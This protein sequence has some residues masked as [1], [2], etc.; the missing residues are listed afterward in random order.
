MRSQVDIVLSSFFLINVAA[1]LLTA[2]VDSDGILVTDLKVIREQYL[3][4]GGLSELLAAPPLGLIYYTL[5]GDHAD[6]DVINTLALHRLLMVF[7]QVRSV[8]T[9]SQRT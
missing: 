2:Y 8:H 6:P 9:P 5:N 7:R 3:I 1:N 4:H